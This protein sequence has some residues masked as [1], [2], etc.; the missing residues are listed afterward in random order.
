ML[1]IKSCPIIPVLRKI[2]YA[3]SASIIDALYAGGIKAV[4]ITMDT[5]QAE[6][7]ILETVE[8]YADKLLVGAGTVLSVEEGERAIEAGAQ[9]LVSPALDMEVL[10]F[11]I[12]Q[13]IEFIPGVFTP[14]EM[15]QAH[16][17]GASMV[18]LFPAASLG[19]SFIKDVKGPLGYID[20]MTTG[21]IT[22]E[23]VRSYVDAGAVIIGA[24][25]ALVKKEFIEKKDWV[26]L[27]QEAESWL[28]IVSR[29]KL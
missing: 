25:S 12:C 10:A 7:I 5:E 18:K 26:S 1:E 6:Q 13:Q 24:G 4:E 14:S 23:T 9:F 3:E 8:R 27:T 19:P 21:G 15:L 11:A 28:E 22:R 29:E 16:K 17:A 2:P 20:I